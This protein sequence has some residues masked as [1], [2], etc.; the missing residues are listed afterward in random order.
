VIEE[1]NSC[2]NPCIF[3]RRTYGHDGGQI[4]NVDRS[5]SIWCLFISAKNRPNIIRT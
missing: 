3:D 4:R 5:A 1:R 2:L